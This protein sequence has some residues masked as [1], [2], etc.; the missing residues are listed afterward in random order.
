MPEHTTTRRKVPLWLLVFLVFVGAGFLQAL[1]TNWTRPISEF[2]E[3]A[4]IDYAYRMSQGSLPT[5]D[6]RYT[7]RTLAIGECIDMQSQD[8]TCMDSTTREAKE[9]WPD[10]F[11]YQAQQLPLGYAPYAAAF[12]F[13]VSDSANHFEQIRILRLT[14]MAL[15]VLLGVVWSFLITALTRS[16]LP[17]LATTLVLATNPLIVDSFSYVTNDGAAI[18]VGALVSLWLLRSLS[19]GR[20]HSM[21]RTVVAAVVLGSLIAFTKITALA[22]VVAIAVGVLIT[23]K[24][25]RTS[26]VRLWWIGTSILTATALAAQLVHTLL[27]DQRST[28]DSN[29]PF[30]LMLPRSPLP[31]LDTILVRVTDLSAM[32]VG[33]G[34]RTDEVRL[35][36]GMTAPS[37]LT[38]LLSLAA[39]AAFVIALTLPRMKF[40]Q[41][42]ALQPA[43]LALGVLAAA[44]L[45]LVGMPLVWQISGGYLTYVPIGRYLGPVVPLAV[46]VMLVT[47]QRFR[48]AALAVILAGVV[49]AAF[50]TV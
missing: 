39:A 26:P 34:A 46:A 41:L 22:V 24:R 1:S 18:V 50:G 15:W 13:A 29:A 35:E 37:V 3:I 6:D 7:Q 40:P 23:T 30:S 20:N 2:D 31:P 10:G 21:G 38:L 12:A 8:P 47:F 33:S 49:V 9:R 43:S 16:R 42:R 14:S 48:L 19:P 32:V 25:W 4:H 17:A 28:L 45:V 11:S 36:S 5:W 44:A 27:L